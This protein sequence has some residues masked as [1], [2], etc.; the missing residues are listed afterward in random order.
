MQRKANHPDSWEE[1]LRNSYVQLGVHGITSMAREQRNARVKAENLLREFV[2]WIDGGMNPAKL[3]L[4]KANAKV[5]L[6]D[7]TK[8]QFDM[9]AERELEGDIAPE[10]REYTGTHCSVCGEPQYKTPS[11]DV[12]SNMHGGAAPMERTHFGPF[13]HEALFRNGDDD[14]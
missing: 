12:C 9:I 13:G 8:P 1:E 6:G 14:E 7:I 2:T 5:I 10:D 11:G 4:L 3:L